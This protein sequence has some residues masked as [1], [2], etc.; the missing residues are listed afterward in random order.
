[1]WSGPAP[2]TA[3]WR[4]GAR[5]VQAGGEV[6]GRLA[7]PRETFALARRAAAIPASDQEPV[8]A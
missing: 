6:P 5:R 1:M 3:V 4:G 7:Q 2:G 8:I